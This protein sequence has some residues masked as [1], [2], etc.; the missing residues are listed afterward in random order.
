MATV[1]TQKKVVIADDHVSVREGLT[2]IIE[3]CENFV[4]CAAACDGHTLMRAVEQHRPDLVI[5]DIR[6]PVMDGIDAGILI[7]ERFPEIAVIAYINDDS[8]YI[9]S[10]LLQAGFEGI[11]LK[12]SSKKETIMVMNM[13]AEGHL[14][15]C[16]GAEERVNQLIRKKLYNPKRRTVYSFFSEREIEV[17]RLICQELTS[18]QIAEE[19]GLS[20]RTIDCYREKLLRKTACVNVAGLV[21]YAY[22]AGI[23]QYNK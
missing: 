1:P 20:E 18:K 4:V 22:G 13:V 8:D 17:L 19:M 16:H 15:F 14:F 6:M 7:K 2:Q 21:S 23:V 10:K 3:S 11:I 9:F 12:R 5:S